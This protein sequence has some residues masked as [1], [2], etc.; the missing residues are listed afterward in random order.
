MWLRLLILTLCIGALAGAC[1]G[2]DESTGRVTA[3]T[4]DPGA[5]AASEKVQ[6]RVDL[7]DPY[8]YP[9]VDGAGPRVTLQVTGGTVEGLDW[10]AARSTVG[11]WETQ[12]GQ[13]IIA[14]PNAAMYWT[15]PEEPGT[16]KLTVGFDGS[17]KTKRVEIR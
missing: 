10:N 16:F 9:G 11:G 7:Y 15:L 3:I 2:V 13:S 5:P 4:L 1:S 14:Y 12:D 8:L 17:T 6:I